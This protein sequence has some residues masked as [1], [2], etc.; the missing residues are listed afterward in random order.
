VSPSEEE[1]DWLKEEMAKRLERNEK[2][3]DRSK[4]KYDHFLKPKK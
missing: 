4:G 3:K 1:E 2:V